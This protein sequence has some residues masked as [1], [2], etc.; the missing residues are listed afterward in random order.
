LDDVCRVLGLTPVLAQM[1]VGMRWRMYLD[2]HDGAA[3]GLAEADYIPMV[4]DECP[5]G[6][7]H[8]EQG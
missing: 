2:A 5:V 1:V 7:G 6:A 3:I 8:S 4:N